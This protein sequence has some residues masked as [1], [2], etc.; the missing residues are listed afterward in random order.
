MHLRAFPVIFCPRP[1]AQSTKSRLG[2]L[3]F[4]FRL[5]TFIRRRLLERLGCPLKDSDPAP[6][7]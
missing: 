7:L 2:Q 6:V 4:R 1:V 3:D 5:T